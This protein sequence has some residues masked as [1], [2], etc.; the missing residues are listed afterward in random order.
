MH[1]VAPLSAG[2]DAD[3]LLQSHRMTHPGLSGSRRYHDGGTGHLRSLEKGLNP[4]GV[5][6]IVVDYKKFHSLK[7]VGRSVSGPFRLEANQF[8]KVV[9]EKKMRA[10][11]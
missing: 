10:A 1:R 5:D 9:L 3:S 11:Q 6:A 8:P 2:V 7:N 4:F